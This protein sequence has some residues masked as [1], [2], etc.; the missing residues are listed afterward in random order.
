MKTSIFTPYGSITKAKGLT[1]H[2]SGLLLA[3]GDICVVD[4][5]NHKTD[6]EVIG[7]D[8]VESILMVYDN[9]GKVSVGSIVYKKSFAN[10]Y[11]YCDEYLGNVLDCFGESDTC[12]VSQN[13]RPLSARKLKFS[14]RASVSEPL[15]VGIAAINGLLTLGKGQR[16]GVMAG[17]GVGKSVLQ[18]MIAKNTQ[19]DICVCALIGERSREVIDFVEKT[20]TEETR[21]KTIVV[22]APADSS[23]MKK[24]RAGEYAVR[25]AEK[26][27]EEGK[28]VV[29]LFD[30]L[31]R[32]AHALREVGLAAGE[33][34]TSKGYPPSVFTKLPQL[35]ERSGNTKNG[36]ISSVYTVLMDGDDENDPV[37]DS[38]RAILDGHIMLSRKLASQGHYPAIDITKSVSRC[39][40]D[41]VDEQT[42]H[43]VHTVKRWLSLYAENEEFLAM[44]AYQPGGR[45][46]LDEAIRKV[47]AVKNMVC[48]RPTDVRNMNLSRQ[49]LY[50]L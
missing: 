22:S 27:A 42:L 13:A 18:T 26:Y 2:V 28:D 30:S 35:V 4:S 19:A 41:L 8:G 36:S 38:A 34:P 3:V 16:V 43:K 37:V 21:R 15:D 12:H 7:I 9:I 10:S 24:L 14:D 45:P 32:Y 1:V 48:Q 50:S 33:P 29:L 20:L 49:Y 25:I 17:S 5:V 23:P 44:G 6:A 40:A 39:M 11:D 47:D 46:D 31:T